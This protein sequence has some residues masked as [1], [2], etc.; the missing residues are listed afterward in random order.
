M[1]AT[2]PDV[3]ANTLTYS[4]VGALPAGA[5]LDPATGL[6]SWTPSEAQGPQTVNVTVRMQDA[7]G[8]SDEE[9]F[10]IVVAEVNTAPELGDIAGQTVDEG[11]AR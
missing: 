2:D 4:V 1:P 8:A 5:T 3:P 7:G 9:T 6:F 10:Q 11:S